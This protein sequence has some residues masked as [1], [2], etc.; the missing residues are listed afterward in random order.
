MFSDSTINEIRGRIDIIDLI[1]DYTPLKRA[2]RN[3]KALCPFH[4][5]KTASF[6]V[7]PE[8]QIFYCFGC[9]AGGDA[10]AF[11]MKIDGLTFP[12]ALE[13]LGAKVGVKLQASAEARVSSDEKE[14]LYQAN[15]VAAW[16]YHENLKKSP[17]AEKARAYLRQRGLGEAEPPLC[18]LGTI[19]GRVLR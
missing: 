8:K 14:T 10:F 16:H 5:E 6:I 9:H 19:A 11:L 17:A 4:Q 12:E 7:N 18:E 2:G 3:F 15:R 13:K 1:S